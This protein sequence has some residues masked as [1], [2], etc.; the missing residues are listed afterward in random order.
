MNIFRLNALRF[1]CRT[2]VLNSNAFM[3]RTI[4]I[5]V[6]SHEDSFKFKYLTIQLNRFQQI[7]MSS[8]SCTKTTRNQ[9]IFVLAFACFVGI[10]RVIALYYY[11]RKNRF[12]QSNVPIINVIKRRVRA[13]VQIGNSMVKWEK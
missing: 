1:L 10:N 9:L 5:P 13:K 12:L 11:F 8:S 7:F 6:E 4:P 2:A 3:Q